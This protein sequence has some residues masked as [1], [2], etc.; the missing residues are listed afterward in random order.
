MEME[1]CDLPRTN[2]LHLRPNKPVKGGLSFLF[3]TNRL[4]FLFTLPFGLLHCETLMPDFTWEFTVLLSQDY[5][6]R[7]VI[8]SRCLEVERH[9]RS[10][11][12]HPACTVSSALVIQQTGHILVELISAIPEN[13]VQHGQEC[14]TVRRCASTSQVSELNQEPSDVYHLCMLAKQIKYCL[15]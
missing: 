6:E 7:V 14:F 1:V 10:P 12:N 11:M 4:H 13:E 2:K 9:R 15:T 3:F 8:S 5:A